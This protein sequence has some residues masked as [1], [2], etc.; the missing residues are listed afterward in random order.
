ESIE[1][2][3]SGAQ[4]AMLLPDT[5]TGYVCDSSDVSPH[6]PMEVRALAVIERPAVASLAE[7]FHAAAGSRPHLTALWGPPGSGKSTVVRQLARIAR[8]NGFVPVAAR[9]VNSRYSWLWHGRSVFV[10]DD[11]RG[12][13]A[14]S[15]LLDT[16]TRNPQPHVLMIAGTSE[17]KA[18][19]GVAL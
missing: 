1:R 4:G 7:M 15:A 17:E 8:L 12:G 5:S 18:L 19:D 9:L 3:R 14:W 2:V 16:T 13:H 10:I 6:V 11:G